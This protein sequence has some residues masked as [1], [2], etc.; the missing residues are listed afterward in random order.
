[1]SKVIV[2]VGMSLDGYIAGPN[3]GPHNKLPASRAERTR[4]LAEEPV[5][6]RAYTV[7][8]CLSEQC[9]SVVSYGYGKRIS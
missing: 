8:N 9:G 4:A 5:L 2:D 3:A 6:R 7:T 1:M